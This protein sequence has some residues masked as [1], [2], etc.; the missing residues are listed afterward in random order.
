MSPFA[1]ATALLVTGSV[2]LLGIG[3]ALLWMIR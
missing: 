3:T 2:Y 1:L